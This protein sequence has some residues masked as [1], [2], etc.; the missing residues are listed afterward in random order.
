MRILFV[1]V[2]LSSVAFGQ[3]S[4]T[5]IEKKLDNFEKYQFSSRSS[6]FY[7]RGFLINNAVFPSFSTIL[8]SYIENQNDL[9]NYRDRI[10]SS[11]SRY[12]DFSFGSSFLDNDEENVTALRK[13]KAARKEI[14]NYIINTYKSISNYYPI[15][16]KK[17]LL[18]ELKYI[19]SILIEYPK[20]RNKYISYNNSQKERRTEYD[21][22]YNSYI[23]KYGDSKSWAETRE[24]MDNWEKKYCLKNNIKIDEFFE[25]FPGKFGWDEAWLYRRIEYDKIPIA[26][27]RVY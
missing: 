9:I 22:E 24:H 27:L 14:V 15:Y 17:E 2:F 21:N 4:I 16:K 3:K 12:F 8:K 10:F 18:T 11:Y 13:S 25:W 5:T 6:G 20:N 26:E 1:F 23:K 19:D 7:K